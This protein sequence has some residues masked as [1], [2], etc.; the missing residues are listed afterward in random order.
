MRKGSSFV[1]PQAAGRTSLNSD[2][3]F[4]V[5]PGDNTAFGH[6]YLDFTTRSGRCAF[7][8]GTGQFTHF[9]ASVAVSVDPTTRLTHWDGTYWFTPSY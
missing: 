6:C 5:L 4:Y 3:V 8:S 1:C 7:S 9:H 2:V